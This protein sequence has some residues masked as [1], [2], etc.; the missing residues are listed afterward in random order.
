[1]DKCIIGIIGNVGPEV[2][3]TLQRYIREAAQSAGAATDQDH[4]PVVVIKN[5]SIPDRNAA[6]LYGGASPVPGLLESCALLE[7]CGAYIGALPSNTAQY[8]RKSCQV[9]TPV[10]IPPLLALTAQTC[11]RVGGDTVGVLCTT[12]TRKLNIYTQALEKE[13][14]SVVYPPEK[15]QERCVQGAI[16]GTLPASGLHNMRAGN[17]LKSGVH[18]TP[19]LLLCEAV[20]AMHGARAVIMGCTEIPLIAARLQIEFPEITFIDPMRIL[21]DYC[22]RLRE[23]V[24][25]ALTAKTPGKAGE[26]ADITCED[27]AVAYLVYRHEQT[28]RSISHEFFQ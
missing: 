20:S 13:G 16:Y 3:E 6:I 10:Y 1:M 12:A 14:V 21:A 17:G 26:A 9:E 11:R 27:E 28:N 22:L 24:N 7:R 19:F 18:D 8:F 2:D 5:P 4:P 23:R 25:A 15:L